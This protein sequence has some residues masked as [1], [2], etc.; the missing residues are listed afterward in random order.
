MKDKTFLSELKQLSG[1]IYKNNNNKKPSNWILVSKEKNKKTGFYAE[2][3]AKN[4]N[5]IIVFRGTDMDKGKTEKFKDLSSDIMMDLFKLPPAQIINAMNYYKKIRKDF[6]NYNIM[7]TGHSLGG[8]LAQI[9]GAQYGNET[10]TFNAYGT[11]NLIKYQVKNF[12]NI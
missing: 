1:C 11:A 5:I 2:T 6:E 7:F 4:K 3:Y 12:D 10:Y 8:S 9:L